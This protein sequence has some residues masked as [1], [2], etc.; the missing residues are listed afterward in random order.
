MARQANEYYSDSWFKFAEQE[1]LRSHGVNVTINRK[2]LHK[3]GR[4][5]AVGTTEDIWPIGGTEVYPSTNSIDSLVSSSASDTGVQVYLE[6]MTIADEKL[7]FTT[8]IVTL[9]GQNRVALTTPLCRCTRM[10]GVAVGT[11]YVYE[12]SA[13]SGGVP[14]DS[15]KIH[16]TLVIGDHTSLKAGTSIADEN[17]FVLTNYWAELGKASSS[18][19]ADIRVKICAF[20]D[21][22]IGENFYID[23]V[24]TV[25]LSAPLNHD[26][27][28]FKLVKPNSDI[29]VTGTASSGSLDIKAGFS[30]FFAD[31]NR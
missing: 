8:Q 29:V 2:S 16:N 22:I 10:R 11:V 3:Y 12:L 14:T 25:S 18:A 23:Q 19:A 15:T 13:I 9:N 24:R 26:F 28:P 1:L 30:G 17:Y 21:T 31:I 7:S 27:R 6:G 4:N 20:G 5:L